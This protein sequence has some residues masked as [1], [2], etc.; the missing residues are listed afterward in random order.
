MLTPCFKRI[1]L[2][3]AVVGCVGSSAV[4]RTFRQAVRS[5]K[6]TTYYRVGH[7][8]TM[9]GNGPAVRFAPPNTVPNVTSEQ[10]KAHY[11]QS[12]QRFRA[13]ANQA[14]SNGNSVAASHK[15]E[16]ASQQERILARLNGK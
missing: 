7:Y 10:V 15:A 1:A 11:R 2:A 4:A 16:L 3:F 6:P 8:G 9:L 13:L 12:A 5:G 14:F